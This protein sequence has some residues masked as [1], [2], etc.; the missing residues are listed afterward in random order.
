LIERGV[1]FV[2]VSLG[3]QG[4]WDTHNNNFSVVRELSTELDAGWSSLMD[5]LASR[6]LLASTTILWMGEFGRTPS[7]NGAGG[8]DHYPNAWTAVLAGGG[9]KGG[10]AWGR[11]SA[12]GMK[13]EDGLVTPGDLLATLCAALGLNPNQQ[14]VSDVG[15]PFKLADGKPVKGILT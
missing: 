7:I 10:Q 8:R 11:T 6:G 12:D 1:S 13:V 3:D 9:I 14:N 5:D 4:R 15:R 2:E